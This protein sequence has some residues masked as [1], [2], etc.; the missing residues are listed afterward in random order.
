MKRKVICKTSFSDLIV[1][2]STE[3]DSRGNV[4]HMITCSNGVYEI[5]HYYFEKLSSALDFINSNF[6]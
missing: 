3:C 5:E 4:I 1:K 6:E 2:L